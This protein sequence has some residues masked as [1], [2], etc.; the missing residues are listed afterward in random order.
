MSCRWKWKNKQ[1]EITNKQ[2]IEE[3]VEARKIKSLIHFTHYINHIVHFVEV[4]QQQ[5]V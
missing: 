3:I 1:D 5:I 4:M 2:S